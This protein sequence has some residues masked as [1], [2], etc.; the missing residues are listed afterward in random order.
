[1]GSSK[2]E[3]VKS[4]HDVITANRDFFREQ[5][6]LWWETY[7]SQPRE[8]RHLPLPIG[9]RDYSLPEKS[10]VVSIFYDKTWMPKSAAAFSKPPNEEVVRCVIWHLLMTD[11]KL[12]EGDLPC[13][14]S[15]LGEVKAKGSQNIKLKQSTGKGEGRTKLIAALTKHHQYANGGCLNLEPIGNNE[16]AR[17]ADVS[18]STASEFFTKEFKGYTKYRASCGNASG[19][20]AAIKLLN[21]EF[22]PHYLFGTKPPSENE[23]E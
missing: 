17:M 6:R 22:S 18:I 12:S 14:E 4:V 15:F 16:L 11:D 3:L 2:P 10:V 5:N 21:Q 1:M 8:S 7:L 9:Q 19:L 23:E 13:I 20:V